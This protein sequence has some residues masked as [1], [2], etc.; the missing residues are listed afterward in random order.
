MTTKAQWRHRALA[1]EAEVASLTTALRDC[2]E[3]RPKGIAVQ[4]GFQALLA[5]DQRR[6]LDYLADAGCNWLRVSSMTQSTD[7]EQDDQLTI[8]M[9][10]A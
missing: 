4:G 6:E 7:N 10:A 1:A 5:D 2:R 8:E 3:P 9:E